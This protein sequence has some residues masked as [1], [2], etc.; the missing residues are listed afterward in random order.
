MGSVFVPMMN[1]ALHSRP[2][3]ASPLPSG[4]RPLA[5]YSAVF[6]HHT[7]ASSPS[8]FH[9]R[10]FR[11]RA[12]AGVLWPLLTPARSAPPLDGGYQHY[13]RTGQ[14]SPDKN[15][16]FPLMHLPHLLP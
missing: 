10:P 3:A 13:W 9:V 6:A 12:L 15:G 8:S 14:A 5:G 1:S 4:R 11:Q 16:I 2:L 7:N